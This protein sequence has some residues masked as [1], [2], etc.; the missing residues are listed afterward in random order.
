MPALALA[1][2]ETESHPFADLIPPSPGS[3]E[4][5]GGEFGAQAFQRDA[6]GNVT[7]VPKALPTELSTPNPFSDLI[8]DEAYRRSDN[9]AGPFDDLIP[10][11]PT[12]EAEKALAETPTFNPRNEQISAAP[13]F[14]GELH[15]GRLGSAY[16][17]AKEMVGNALKPGQEIEPGR[18]KGLLG[19]EEQIPAS[20]DDSLPV[21]AAKA[22]INVTN[23]TAAGITGPGMLPL[24]VIG[25]AGGAASRILAGAFGA[26]IASH[27]PDTWQQIQEADKT[28]PWFRNA[29]RQD[30]IPPCK[31]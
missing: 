15:A 28:E 7:D 18:G 29:L 14:F 31:G 8:P 24:A 1:P 10:R 11:S 3:P 12:S 13:T 6:A 16:Y 17:L 20:P 30:W 2:D 22:F 9:P 23:R 4:L 19:T 26:D 25:G 21:R 5:I 27:A